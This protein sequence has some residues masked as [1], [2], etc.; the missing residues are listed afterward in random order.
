M[1]V[2]PT[3]HGNQDTISQVDSTMLCD[4]LAMVE[5]PEYG[6]L[7][8]PPPPD[9][10]T[11]HRND[12]GDGISYILGGLFLL[13]LI[14]ALR[15]RDNMKHIVAMFNSLM[16]TRVRQN[17]FDDTVRETSL[18]VLLNLLWCASAGIICYCV[19][20]NSN[21]WY[22]YATTGMLLTMA[23]AVAYS[24]FML[25][26]YSGVGWIF[27]DW[28]HAALW[29][30]GYAAS[31]ALTAPVFFLTAL[32]AICCPGQS[33]AVGIFALIVFVTGKLVFILK[34]YRIFFNQFSSWVLFLCYLC[35]LEIVPLILCYR[36]ANLLG[37]GL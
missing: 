27:S 5:E 14:I 29:V 19:Y 25:I 9:D 6:I 16:A 23:M 24:I 21:G 18:L 10:P 31:Q 12:S 17:A 15:F 2:A 37:R 32:L 26:S 28:D 33:E 11:P 13:T 3:E 4:S 8:T 20:E 22:Q 7:L 35:S 34:G 1:V 30:K 36:C